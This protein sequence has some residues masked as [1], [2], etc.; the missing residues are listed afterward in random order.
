MEVGIAVGLA[1]LAVIVLAHFIVLW[2]TAP[3]VRPRISQ[4]VFFIGIV[5]ILL[6]LVLLSA[7]VS[8]TA[9]AFYALAAMLTYGALLV[10]YL[11]FYY[12]VVA[13]LSLQSLIMLNKQPDDSLPITEL[14]ERFAS[15]QLVKKRMATMAANGFVTQHGNAY[16]LSAKGRFFASTFLWIKTFWKLGPG[17]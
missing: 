17:G 14:R 11:P 3:S 12:S 6:T 10:L 4:T 9:L 16:V 2:T 15:I 7:E 1:W 13:S 8:K 5:G